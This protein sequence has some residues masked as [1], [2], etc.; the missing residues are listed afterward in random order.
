MEN[1]ARR[2]GIILMLGTLA[3]SGCSTFPVASFQ[4]LN[5]GRTTSDQVRQILG[6]PTATTAVD[7]RQTWH[8]G[9]YRYSP[10]NQREHRDLVI[11]F[12]ARGVIVAYTFNLP[13]P[14][15]ATANP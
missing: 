3:L 14:K 9:P 7:G 13:Y 4:S 8:Y 10:F 5:I 2:A 11:R 12:D 1:F 6:E 15:S